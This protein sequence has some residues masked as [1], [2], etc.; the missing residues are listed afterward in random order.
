MVRRALWRGFSAHVAQTAFPVP[1]MRVVQDHGIVEIMRGCPN[2]CR[3]CHATVYYRACRLKRKDLVQREVE[4][5]VMAAGYRQITLSSLSSGDYRGIFELV[6]ELNLQYAPFSVSFAL[7]SLRVDSLALQLLREIS[8]VRKSG[9]T[10]AVETAREEWQAELRKRASVEK[11]IAVLREAKGLGWKQAKFYFMVGLPASFDEDESSSIVDFLRAVRAATGMTLNVNVAGF[12]PKPH[13]PYQR[14]AQI[15]EDAGAGAHPGG[16][17]RPDRQRLQDRLPRPVSL[18]SRGDSLSRRPQGGTPCPG[19]L[20]EGSAPGCL[21][22]ARE[23]GP[24]ARGD[25]RG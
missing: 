15:G 19:G 7:P 10:F 14:A 4:R 17:G 2:A 11:I 12:I 21:G 23:H 3:F 20:P 18:D 16:E 13:T 9:L 1:S 6:R 24:L 22:G 25:C 5:L 8:E